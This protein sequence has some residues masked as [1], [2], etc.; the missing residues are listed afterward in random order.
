[1]AFLWSCPPECITQF[2]AKVVVAPWR[3]TGCIPFFENFE[4][5]EKFEKFLFGQFATENPH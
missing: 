2:A 3:G 5:F 1:L 4:K